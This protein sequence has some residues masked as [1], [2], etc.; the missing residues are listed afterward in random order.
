MSLVIIVN[1]LGNGLVMSTSYHSGWGF[2]SGNCSNVIKIRV[3][4]E[5][6]RDAGE[7]HTFFLVKRIILGIWRIGTLE[8]VC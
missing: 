2:I 8:Q 4:K 6:Y 5:G 7:V 1:E 3:C